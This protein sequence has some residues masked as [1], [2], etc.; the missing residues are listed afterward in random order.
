MRTQ[1][2]AGPLSKATEHSRPAFKLLP[3]SARFAHY[4][5]V[6]RE[7]LADH[8]KTLTCVAP[9]A[10]KA[11][12]VDVDKFVEMIARHDFSKTAFPAF[13]CANTKDLVPGRERLMQFK[14]E[15]CP[16]F[17][18][19]FSFVQMHRLLEVTHHQS[20]LTKTTGHSLP[21]SPMESH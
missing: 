4:A 13:F 15:Q 10:A 19:M 1:K 5:T 18:M 3:Q 2:P 7:S 9:L 12:G 21:L 20:V 16:F 17:T 6:C 14:N 11:A 8:K